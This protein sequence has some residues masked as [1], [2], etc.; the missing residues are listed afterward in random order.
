MHS[1]QTLAI[2]AFKK[3]LKAIFIV[4]IQSIC[5]FQYSTKTTYSCT[6]ILLFE[7]STE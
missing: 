6:S 3:Q 1:K 5:W 2:A 7:K 4:L